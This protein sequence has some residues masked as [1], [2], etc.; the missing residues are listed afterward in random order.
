MFT[1]QQLKYFCAAYRQLNLH[2]ASD[3]LNLTRQALGRSLAA[4]EGEL[5]GALF[6][7]G[8]EGLAPTELA[9]WFFPDAE[10]LCEEAERVYGAA[11]AFV[12][13]GKRTLRVGA[14]FSAVET[15]YPLLPLAFAE[16]HPEVALELVERPDKELEDLVATG[17]LEGALVI[18][19]ATPRTDITAVCVHRE[20][21]GMLMRAD[22][23]LAGRPALVG[24]DLTGVPLLMV[25][26]QFKARDQLVR[27]LERV[28]VQPDVAF[29]SGDFSLLI[30]MCRMGRGIVP[31][32]LSRTPAVAVDG[33][34][35]VP[36]D[37][38]WD[39]GWQID[40][41]CKEGGEPSET[42]AAFTETLKCAP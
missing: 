13:A 27:A 42:L 5:G 24:T 12:Q 39:P 30:A 35:V 6:D 26:E 41:I 31:L 1:Y 40:F 19:P 36:L 9:Q 3:E 15:A 16:K 8:R 11:R 22:A 18:G 10:R 32:P 33:L 25:S 23:S 38:S 34:V 29:T 20:P 37:P 4:L 2:R 17:G 7:R 14:T 21:L 28:G